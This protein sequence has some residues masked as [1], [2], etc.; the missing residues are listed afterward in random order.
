MAATAKLRHQCL[1]KQPAC[2][3]DPNRITLHG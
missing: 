2:A 3:D 1:S